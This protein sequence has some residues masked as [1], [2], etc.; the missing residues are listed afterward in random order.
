MR[1]GAGKGGWDTG[2]VSGRRKS[3]LEKGEQAEAGSHTGNT[4]LTSDQGRGRQ[5]GCGERAAP[6]PEGG[7]QRPASDLIRLTV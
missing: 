5:K 7:R 6:R 4:K 2:Q 1:A 3:E